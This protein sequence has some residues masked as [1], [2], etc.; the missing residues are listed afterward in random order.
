MTPQIYKQFLNCADLAYFHPKPWVK[1]PATGD[2]PPDWLMR[3]TLALKLPLPGVEPGDLVE[4]SAETFINSRGLIGSYGSADNK[5]TTCHAQVFVRVATEPTPDVEDI[6]E[7]YSVLCTPRMA[8]AGR[9]PLGNWW[10]GNGQPIATVSGEDVGLVPGATGYTKD[11][12]R[13]FAFVAWAPYTEINVFVC[14][15]SGACT[16]AKGADG[17]PKSKLM[18]PPRYYSQ[19]LVKATKQTK[20]PASTAVRDAY[21]AQVRG[22][23]DT[24]MGGL[25]PIEGDGLSDA[26]REA[27]ALDRARRGLALAGRAKQLMNAEVNGW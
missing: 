3:C 18:L 12:T 13:M 11:P 8:A 26:E 22:I 2:V 25:I 19:I 5:P 1:D 14:P 17:K 7:P 20:P 9:G 24:L 6:G 10:D 27:V 21:D 16:D 23:F 15:K 4:G